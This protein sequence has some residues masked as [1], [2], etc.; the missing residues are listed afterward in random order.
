VPTVAIG[1]S[2]ILILS[3]VVS[4]N[5]AQEKLTKLAIPDGTNGEPMN[6]KPFAPI[7]VDQGYHASAAAVT[8]VTMGPCAIL[9]LGP[10]M[11][12]VNLAQEIVVKLAS[13]PSST[14]SS[15]PMNAKMFA[16]PNKRVVQAKVL[17]V[18]A[19]VLV[20]QAKISVV[21]RIAKDLKA[22]PMFVCWP[23]MLN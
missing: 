1:P 14:P 8:N 5:V 21:H 19:K 3:M 4:V 15:E 20:V 6:A 2:A 17:A 22:V 7:G 23:T 12:G 13:I 10:L 18:K 16:P 9:I 11:V